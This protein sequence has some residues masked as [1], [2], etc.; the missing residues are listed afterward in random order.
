M[1]LING[2]EQSH[3]DVSDRGLAYGDGLFE[4]IEIADEKAIHWH[5]HIERL[6]LGCQVLGLTCPDENIL[7]QEC[8]RLIAGITKGII[9]IIITRGATGRGYRPSQNPNTT[10]ILSIH[11]W[12]KIPAVYYNEGIRLYSCETPASINCKLAGVKTLCRLDQVLAQSEWVEGEYEEGLMFDDNQLVIEGTKTN[13]FII[14]QGTLH[15]PSLKCAGIKGIMREIVLEIARVLN[16][17]IIETE[18]SKTEVIDADEIF[19]CNSIIKIWPVREYLNKQYAVGDIT[20]KFINNI[21][22]IE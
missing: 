14:K 1:I 3:V 9:K 17:P 20:R 7:A 5:R 13:V 6:R 8:D 10:R 15:T 21:G 11:P 2:K 4:T 16:I 12:P 18:I 22:H 19:V